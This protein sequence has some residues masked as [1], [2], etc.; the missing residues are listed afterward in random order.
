MYV[1][2]KNG[3]ISSFVARP[4]WY[5]GVD[6]D[7]NG[8]PVTD[9]YLA[10][11]GILPIDYTLP[12]YDPQRQIVV[13]N[14]VSQW[15]ILGNKAVVSYTINNIPFETLRA[16][17]LADINS[18]S[19]NTVAPYLEGYPEFEMKTW[20]IQRLEALNYAK[21]AASPTPWCDVA[22]AKRGV[23]RVTFISLVAAKSEAYTQISS[24]VAGYRQGLE[25]AI[26]NIDANSPTAVDDLLK[27][28]WTN[29]IPQ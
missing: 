23:D 26:N 1:A 28:V 12:H 15:L 13:Q 2:L 3:L 9:E 11:V 6:S 4:L 24:I 16:R 19:E 10:S 29:P 25:V 27:I 21:D 5:T 18:K 8:V 14:P 20:P 22:A 7:G 17:K